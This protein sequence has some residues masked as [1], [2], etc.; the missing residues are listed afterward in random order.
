MLFGFS[1]DFLILTSAR[2]IS[3][4][5][6]E[7]SRFALPVWIYQNGGGAIGIGFATAAGFLPQVIV[8]PL[9]GVV[10]DRFER[11]TV[12]VL[13]DVMLTVISLG[14]I[15]ATGLRPSGLRW[16]MILIMLAAEGALSSIQYP[17]LQVVTADF[18]STNTLPRLNGLISVTE[19]SAGMLSPLLAVGFLA[20]F[21]LKGVILI[22]AVTFVLSGIITSWISFPIRYS[23]PPMFLRLGEWF[24]ESRLGF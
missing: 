23:K 11:K 16:G 17:A 7:M 22:D 13:C 10:I 21:G 20:Q 4:L 5:G 15:M 2:T 1:A 12:L 8:G 9:T 6:S 19:T 3:I 14:L 18:A 24:A